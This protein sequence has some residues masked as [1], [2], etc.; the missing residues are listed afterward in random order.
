MDHTPNSKLIA[1]LLTI[2]SDPSPDYMMRLC[3]RAANALQAS[4]ARIKALTACLEGRGGRQALQLAQAL[5]DCLE[6]EP[7]GRWY[8]NGDDPEMLVCD[9]ADA[10]QG[11]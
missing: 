6:Q 4:D 11:E 10:L 3:T 1:E 5:V 9:L 8:V 2:R 7:S